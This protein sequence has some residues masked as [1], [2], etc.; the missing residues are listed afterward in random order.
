MLKFIK[1]IPLVFIL[2]VAFGAGL[3]VGEEEKTEAPRDLS[4]RWSVHLRNSLGTKVCTFDIEQEDARL[5]GKILIYAEPETVLDG[6]FNEGN[7]IM[8]WGVHKQ[9]RTGVA[10]HL[11]FKGV[12]EGEP[13][14]EILK[15]QAEYF[16]KR[17]DFV[18]KRK[19]KKKKR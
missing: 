1:T 16:D 7:E 5:R 18:A 10:T 14:E 3:T 4:G 2:L 17:Y 11:E 9:E 12:F 8:L 6:R 13:G 15:G 19:R